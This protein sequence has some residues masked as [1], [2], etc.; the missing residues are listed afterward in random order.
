[1]KKNSILYFYNKRSILCNSNSYHHN[2]K[3]LF[4]ANCKLR[5]IYKC[6]C[7]VLFWVFLSQNIWKLDFREFLKY[8]NCNSNMQPSLR[9]LYYFIWV[10]FR[11][12]LFHVFLNNSHFFFHLL[13]VQ[14][15]TKGEK[16]RE[17]CSRHWFSRNSRNSQ[18][19]TM[20]PELLWGLPFG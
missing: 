2:R 9:I 13:E 8:S 15:D 1:M 14:S 10:K 11:F 12:S 18:A 7:H 16:E 19:M 3:V 4:E 5:Y 17:K 20:V 6:G